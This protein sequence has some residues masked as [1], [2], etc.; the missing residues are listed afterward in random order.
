MGYPLTYRQYHMLKLHTLME[1]VYDHWQKDN[2]PTA[3]LMGAFIHREYLTTVREYQ[4]RQ[5]EVFRGAEATFNG[6][7]VLLDNGEALGMVRLLLK[8]GTSVRKEMYASQP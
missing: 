6:L 2:P 1:F 3:L 7:P 4:M 8:T 5:P